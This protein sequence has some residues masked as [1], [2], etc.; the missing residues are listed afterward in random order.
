MDV[1]G[2]PP[3]APAAVTAAARAATQAATPKPAPPAA[4][5]RPATPVSGSSLW[6][7]LTPDEQEFFTRQTALG[8]LT[9]GPNKGGATATGPNCAPLGGRIDVKG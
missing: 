6:D 2:I 5:A 9:Y 8:A 7:L 4:T 3:I 1:S